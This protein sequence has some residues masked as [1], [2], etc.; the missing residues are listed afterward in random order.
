M[1]RASGAASARG[2]SRPQITGKVV[3]GLRKHAANKF[4]RPRVRKRKHCHGGL[5]QALLG[6][7]QNSLLFQLF[8]WLLWV[9]KALAVIPLPYTK[10]LF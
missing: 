10:V 7:V 3:S 9:L 5:S 8:S 4:S 2:T 1:T 6:S